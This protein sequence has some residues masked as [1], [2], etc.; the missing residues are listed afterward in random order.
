MLHIL[1]VP[2]T[3]GSTIQYIVRQYNKKFLEYRINDHY[4]NLILFDGSMHGFCK[5]GHYLEIKEINDYL[6]NKIDQDI[7]IT[8]LIYPMVDAH[9]DTIINL[10]CKYRSMDNYIFIYV[11][12]IVQAEITILAQYY[13]ISIGSTNLSIEIICGDNQHAIINWNPNY[14]HWDQM[15]IW[16][17]REW[18]SMFY[19]RWVQEWIDARKYVPPNWLTVCSGDILEN[20]QETFLKI[21]NHVGEFNSNLENE[22]NEFIK[23]WKEKQQYLLDEHTVIKNVVEF[24]ISN[25]LYTWP[26]LNIISEAIIQKRLRDQGYV[27]KCYNLNDFP[28]NSLD[29]HNLLERI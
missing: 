27:I 29:L 3:F 8:A 6:D 18:F 12:N 11:D 20:T 24:T 4:K 17:L 2:G 26:K 21:I 15:Q 13:K 1:F 9:A 14:T 10:F 23:V 16:E 5:T 7:P 22:F 19:E 28:T 25:T